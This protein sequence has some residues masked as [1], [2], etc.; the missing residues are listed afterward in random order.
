[1]SRDGL[2]GSTIHVTDLPKVPELR[3][4]RFRGDVDYAAMATVIE[5]SKDADGIER[6]ASAEEVAR[7]YQYLTNCDPVQDMLFA[8]AGRQ[9][10]GYSRVWWQQLPDGE[11]LYRH[12]AFLLPE[13]RGKGI[14]RS[15]L[16]HNERRLR[17]I[18]SAHPPDEPK[19]LESWAADTEV[20]WE[21]LLIDAGYERV[22]HSF[23][24]VRPDLKGIPELPLPRGL[25][26]RPVQPHEYRAVWE[27]AAEAFR[28]EWS[29]TADEW[30]EERYRGWREDPTFMPEL[31]QVA[32]E[33]DE[34]A[35]MVLNFVDAEE[36]REYGRRR[37]YTET[38]CVRRP[39]RQR[40]L[41]RALIARSFGVLKQVGMT[42]AAL[43]VDAQNPNGALA[44]YRSMGF[45]AA[46]RVSTYRKPLNSDCG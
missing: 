9:V 30:T 25:V 22:R 40:G 45:H 26:V 31:W 7:Y 38:I 21:S 16:L 29:Y 32:W 28:D 17:R 34:V 14:R 42:E 23:Q 44:L 20:S 15:M 41:A 10:C 4:R 36:N 37:G 6:T 12:L 46:K 11:R 2:P 39:W 33:G 24:M 35:G 3:F 43:G 18:G 27:A 5:G 8:E 19:Q 13:W 1:M